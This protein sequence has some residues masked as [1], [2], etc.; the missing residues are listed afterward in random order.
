MNI[1]TYNI[2]WMLQNIGLAAIPVLAGSL[3][4]RTKQPYLKVLLLFTWILF[5]PNSLYILTDLKHIPW[6]LSRVEMELLPL[7]IIEFVV[8]ITFGLVSYLL[9]VYALERIINPN[10][11]HIAL[12][13]PSI[14]VFNTIL[15]FG[16]VLGRVHR[17]HSWFIVT[18]PI[19]VLEDVGVTL[20]SSQLMLYVLLFSILGNVMYL[21]FR[22]GIPTLPGFN[23]L[24]GRVK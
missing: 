21:L 15:A 23:L 2:A 17:L 10:N 6:Q 22:R 18:E 14:V 8:L 4:F 5:I 3:L 9:S 19:R 7:W 20:Y 1:I 24:Y 13:Y 11:K 16:L 12:L